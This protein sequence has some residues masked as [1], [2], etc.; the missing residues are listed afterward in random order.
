MSIQETITNI[1]ATT[2]EFLADIDAY[3]T[4]GNKQAAKRSRKASLTLEKLY[5]TYRRESVAATTKIA[6]SI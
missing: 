3:E 6:P 4:K 1:K 5:K 2:E